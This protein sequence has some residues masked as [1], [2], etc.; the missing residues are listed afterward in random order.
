[1][2]ETTDSGSVI[3]VSKGVRAMRHLFTK[4]RDKD[5]DRVEFCAYA[6]RLMTIIW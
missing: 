1:M 3:V 4:I 6:N 5:T 2:N